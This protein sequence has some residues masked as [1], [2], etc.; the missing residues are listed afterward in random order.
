MKTWLVWCAIAAVFNYPVPSGINR[1]WVI[2][3]TAA[4]IAIPINPEW[5]IW[6]FKE[7]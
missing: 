5:L 2:A 3:F 6:K 7:W 4:F 1:L